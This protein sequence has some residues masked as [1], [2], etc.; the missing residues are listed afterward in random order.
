M[1]NPDPNEV[2]KL[3]DECWSQARLELFSWL[4][5]NAE[6]LA[7]L[8]QGAVYILCKHR[9][10]GWTRLLCHAV[11]EIGTGVPEIIMGEKAGMLQHTNRVQTIRELWEASGL[12]ID[13]SAPGGHFLKEEGQAK[14]AEVELPASVY[15]KVAELIRD[16]VQTR[17]SRKE[18]AIRFFSKIAGQDA[19]TQKALRPFVDQWIEVVHWFVNHAHDNR[20][21]DS[22]YDVKQIEANFELFEATLRAVVR[23]FFSTTD[24]LDEILEE[25]NS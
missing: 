19:D 13:G 7:E 5:R 15:F 4:H 8:Y 18:L 9:M 22:E 1:V 14:A 16:H 23:G 25:T 3:P 17:Q 10:S 6:S 12:P 2:P 21:P 24:E 20:R 11:R